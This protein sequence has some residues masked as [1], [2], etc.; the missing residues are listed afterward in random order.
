MIP[1][2]PRDMEETAAFVLACAVTLVSSIFKLTDIS[3]SI[4][5]FSIR[6]WLSW[7]LYKKKEKEVSSVHGIWLNLQEEAIVDSHSL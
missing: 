6:I 7:E 4:R 1:E 2:S 5:L 3:S